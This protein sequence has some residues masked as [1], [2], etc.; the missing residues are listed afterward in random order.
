MTFAADVLHLKELRTRPRFFSSLGGFFFR[1][2]CLNRA[3]GWGGNG[4]S[5]HQRYCHRVAGYPNPV[6]PVTSDDPPALATGGSF[7]AHRFTIRS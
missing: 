2:F 6:A 1:R 7:Y 3:R 5:I 4:A